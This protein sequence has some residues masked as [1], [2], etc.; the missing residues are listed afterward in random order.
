M[1]FNKYTVISLHTQVTVFITSFSEI[2]LLNVR[3]LLFESENVDTELA[4]YTHIV[5]HTMSEMLVYN[6]SENSV[7][8]LQ[9]THLSQIIEYEA[10]SCYSAHSDTSLLAA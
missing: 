8:L 6:E 4:V 2:K 1:T 3:D 7:I 9:K 5:N 10:D